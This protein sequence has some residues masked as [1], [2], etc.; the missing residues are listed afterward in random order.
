MATLLEPSNTTESEVMHTQDPSMMKMSDSSSTTKMT[1][2]IERSVSFSPSVAFRNIIHI[3]DYTNEEIAA[4]WYDDVDL[5]LF[6]VDDIQTTLW[7][8]ANGYL[9]VINDERIC[10]RGLES[11]TQT[12]KASKRQRREAAI[13]V[14]MDELELQ[15][16][17]GITDP[18]MI[19]FAYFE[20]TRLSKALARVMGLS[21]QEAVRSQEPQKPLVLVQKMP[22]Q[23]PILVRRGRAA[24]ISI[25]KRAK[26]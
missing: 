6:K 26:H 5:E 8:M 10:A 17:E 15:M 9:D 14:V 3:S 20:K 19:A 25:P 11:C 24:S 22:N 2:V 18:E 4:C 13:D 21:D 23:E 16:D 1:K 7:L 12:G